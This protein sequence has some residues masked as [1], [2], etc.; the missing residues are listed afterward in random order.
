MT[1]IIILIAI[2]ALAGFD[3]IGVIIDELIN[4][5]TR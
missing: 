2:L 4:K 3:Y 5:E 1:R